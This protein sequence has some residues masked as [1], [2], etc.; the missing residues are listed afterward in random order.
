MAEVRALLVPLG[1]R[2]EKHYYFSYGET[3]P[4]GSLRKRLGRLFYRT[5]PMLKENQTALAV[6]DKRTTLEFAIPSTVHSE[7]RS[8]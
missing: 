6:R 8:L 4:G 1:F 7:L 3:I 5:F 2:L